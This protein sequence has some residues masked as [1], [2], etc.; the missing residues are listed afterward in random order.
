MSFEY[1]YEGLEHVL[2][3]LII[4]IM[5]CFEYTYEGLEQIF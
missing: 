3:M 5:L 4:S 1:T 2:K